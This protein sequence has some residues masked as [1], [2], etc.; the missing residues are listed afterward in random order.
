MREHPPS[1]SNPAAPAVQTAPARPESHPSGE[2]PPQQLRVRF[3]RRMKR[4]RVYPL[5]VELQRLADNR[6]VARA[7]SVPLQARPLIP[8]ALVTPAEAPLDAAWPR[9]VFHLTPLARGRMPDARV[10]LYE[11]GHRIHEM[12]LPM[13]TTS[14]RPTLVWLM[15]AVLLYWAI[16]YGCGVRDYSS[17]KAPIVDKAGGVFA[18]GPV[19]EAVKGVVPAHWAWGQQHLMPLVGD[20]VAPAAQRAYDRLH[21]L[22]KHGHLS[23]WVLAVLLGITVISWVTHTARRARRVSKPFVVGA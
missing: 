4:A 7:V 10:D 18:P 15:L 19:E 21:D 22:E 3:Y 5:Y 20:R 8:G 16:S 13:K 2:G 6:P 23:L 17:A 11:Q 14:Q 12:P 9:A 1:G